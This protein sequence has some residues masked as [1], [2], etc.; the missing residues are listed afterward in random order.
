[1]IKDIFGKSLYSLPENHEKYQFFP[2]PQDLLY[3]IL[4]KT[5]IPFISTA[6]SDSYIENEL[7]ASLHKVSLK[8]KSS[9]IIRIS[10]NNE[11]EKSLFKPK[12]NTCLRESLNDFA[13]EDVIKT[14]NFNNAENMGLLGANPHNLIQVKSISNLKQKLIEEKKL[15][16]NENLK[17][18]YE[19]P[20]QEEDILEKM[21]NK[22]LLSKSGICESIQ[23]SSQILEDFTQKNIKNFMISKTRSENIIKKIEPIEFNNSNKLLVSNKNSNCIYDYSPDVTSSNVDIILKKKHKKSKFKTSVDS[24]FTQNLSIDF[25]KINENFKKCI[26]LIGM[27]LNLKSLD[28]RSVFTICSLNEF[29]INKRFNENEKNIIDFHRKYLS[30]IYPSGARIDSSNYDPVT[31]IL[32]GSQMTAMNMQTNDISL[33][34]Y[35]S[36]FQENGGVNSGYVLKPHFLRSD[37]EPTHRIYPYMMQKVKQTLRIKILSG[38]KISGNN[39]NSIQNIFLEVLLRG[40]RLDEMENKIYKSE[41]IKKNSLYVVFNMVVEFEIRCPDICFI[42]FQLFARN[43]LMCNERMA[44][45]CIPFNCIRQGYRIIPLLNNSLIPIENKLLFAYVQINKL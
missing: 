2:S 37:I 30:R 29:K 31:A 27:K 41:I 18:K 9:Q 1:M 12:D 44:W 8:I 3:K 32:S 38:Q 28:N 5:K 26:C 42:I 35:N 16:K 45:Y 39:K 23:N 6:N 36:I 22:S 14:T 17:E 13:E 7:S 10:N 43:D 15:K 25:S 34:L 4:I 40:H 19:E 11:I 33:L 24:Y 20:K 21:R